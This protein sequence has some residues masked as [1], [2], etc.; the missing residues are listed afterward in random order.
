[1]ALFWTF[2]ALLVAA[3]LATLLWPL[4]RRATRADAPD[5]DLAA[6]AVFRDQKRVLEAELAAG[7]IGAAEYAAALA[8]LTQRVAEE[9]SDALPT[10]V[11]PPQPRAWPRLR[12]RQELHLA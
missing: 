6:L 4:L 3:T 12:D 8:Q 5:A 10:A 1:M 9:S 2:A 7:T 11:R